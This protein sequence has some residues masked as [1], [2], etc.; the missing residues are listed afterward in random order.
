MTRLLQRLLGRTPIGWL[1][2]IHNRPRLVAAIAGIAFANLL[3]LV[4]LGV[5]ASIG[6]VIEL[7]YT[8]LKAD[9]IISPPRPQLTSGEVISRRVMY[10]A[11]ADPAVADAT[12]L[13][14]GTIDW[15]RPDASSKSLT[16]YGM[17]PEATHFAGET[18]AG[19]LGRLKSPDSVLIDSGIPGVERN[20][21]DKG[22]Q[23]LSPESPATFEVDG[24]AISAVG[25]FKVGSGFGADG[26]LF[27]SDQTFMRLF[28][29]RKA[30]TPS[31]ILIQLRPGF[32]ARAAST[33]R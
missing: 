25:S 32:D 3:V 7:I 29:S 17:M 14:L 21:G 27:V 23:Q 5:V 8:P 28:S 24:H 2:L 18:I 6:N 16:V 26:A 4:Q 33:L 22:I 20:L 31:H 1:Q 12:P 30:G 11:L 13:Y 10:S 19:K 15:R 9:I